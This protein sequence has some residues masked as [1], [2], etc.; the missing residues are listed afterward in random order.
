MRN[1]LLLTVVFA[2][3][4]TLLSFAQ[5]RAIGLRQG[6]S[7]GVSYE[8]SL[9]D[10][11]MISLDLELPL[12]MHL[13][14]KTGVFYPGIGIGGVCTY[15]WINPFNTEFPWE[16]KGEWNWYMGVGGGLGGY[17]YP[18]LYNQF[19]VGAAG[20]VGVEYNFWFPLQLSVDY[21][22]CLGVTIQSGEHPVH[23]NAPGLYSGALAFAVRY[24][25]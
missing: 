25:F 21:R 19:F 2:I 10:F 5:P 9:G 7:I 15:D 3:T 11:N 13:D 12:A 14:I 23:F 1:K 4:G 18:N 17:F 22:P 8:H 6:Y 16:H 24:H 20:R